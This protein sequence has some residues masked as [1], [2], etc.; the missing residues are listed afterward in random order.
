MSTYLLSVIVAEYEVKDSY[1]DGKLMYEVIA[2]PAA[3]ED[4]QGDYAFELGQ[5]LL[6]EMNNHT[7]MDFYSV[8]PN[9]KMTQAAIPDFSAG[10]MENWGLLVYR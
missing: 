6:K 3:M 5:E 2:R 10:A 4:N 9:L 8:H 1:D 7:A